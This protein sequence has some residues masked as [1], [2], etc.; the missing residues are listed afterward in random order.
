MKTNSVRSKQ[1]R[2]KIPPLMRTED[3]E[4]DPETGVGIPITDV[5]RGILATRTR[6]YDVSNIVALKFADPRKELEVLADYCRDVLEQ[7]GCPSDRQP[8]W[9]RPHDGE[10]RAAEENEPP[11][12]PGF[13]YALWTSRVET[14]TKPLA[15]ERLA[16][17][18][19]WS[20]IQLLRREGID[21]HIW[22]ISQVVEKYFNFRV[23]DHVNA[24]AYAGI[25]AD[26]GRPAG[27][28]TRHSNAL[29]E[30]KFIWEEAQRFWTTKRIYRNHAKK[31]AAEIAEVVNRELMSRGLLS[32]P[33]ATKTIGDH[34]R[35][36]IRG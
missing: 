35:A 5:R 9:V 24:L 28:E 13:A 33:L 20:L 15:P 8:R 3:V 11:A 12:Q 36:C 2:W 32:K 18:L 1:A 17:D 7:A 4:I 30:R 31:T 29:E 14:L 27:P 22:H 10:W 23:G 26:K 21:G 16:G 25:Q 34:I 6:H 19:L